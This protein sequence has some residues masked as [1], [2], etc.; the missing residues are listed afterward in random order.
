MSHEEAVQEADSVI[1]TTQSDFNPE[2]VSAIEAG[3][4]LKRFFL[5]F[6]NYF[7]MQYNLLQERAAFRKATKQYGRFALDAILIVWIPSVVGKL[8]TDALMGGSDDD[9]DALDALDIIQLTV[10]EPLKG[11]ISMVPLAGQISAF[12][13]AKMAQAGSVTAQAIWGKSPYVGRVGSAPATMLMEGAISGAS[14]IVRII[15][16]DEKVN[17]RTAARNI[18]DLTAVATGMPVGGLK[19]PIGYIAGVVSGDIDEPETALQA[20]RGLVGGK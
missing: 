18:L 15:N 1:R 19:R 2:N 9:D 20:V 10:G 11:T 5:V 7:N 6:Y 12:A 14:D 4:A 16:D 17:G 3:S 8:I 13:G